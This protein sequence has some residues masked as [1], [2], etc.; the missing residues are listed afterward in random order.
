FGTLATRLNDALGQARRALEPHAARLPDGLLAAFDAL[1]AE[2]AQRRIRIAIYGE[3]KA[4]KS[5][6]LN[7]IAGA[8]LSPVAFEPL[9]SVPVRVTYGASTA[10]HVAE[11]RLD[12]VEELERLMRTD[13]RDAA[14]NGAREVV[15]ETPLD[16]L[17]LGGQVDLVD[18]PGVGNAA[19][20]D[21][22]SAEVLGGLDAVVLVVRYPALFTQFTRH[23]TT[24]L[25]ADIGKLFVVWNLDADCVELAPE[26]RRRHAEVLSA[27]VSGAH[28]LFLVD[29]RA[30]FRAMQA[31]DGAGSIASGLSALIA[32]LRRFISSSG[33]QVAALREAA[34][35]SS[36]ALNDAH[37]CLTERHAT[38]DRMLTDTRTRIQAVQA[39]AD[40]ESVTARKRLAD[41]DAEVTRIG[42]H[43]TAGA[44]QLADNL[45]RHL[46][47]ARRRWMRGGDYR[48]L[49]AAITAALR[50]YAGAA[51][52]A[53]EATI[54]ALQGAA[55]NFGASP[56]LAPRAAHVLAVEQ[57]AAQEQVNRAASG[58]WQWVRRAVWHRWY[59]PG[60]ATLER[61][62]IPADVTSQIAWVN[63]MLQATRDAAR[64]TLA[65]RLG[66]ITQRAQAEAQQI[67]LATNAVANQAEFEELDKHLPLVA[68]QYE[69]V[70]RIGTEAR[71]L[72]P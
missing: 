16:L 48:T 13:A 65:T 3:V 64:A 6:L 27:A 52:A 20:F 57:L 5:T 44:S 31:D 37:R 47:S 63:G 51:E 4:G 39:A 40:A 11:C 25:R 7:A 33:R 24:G 38:L 58:R 61:E 70:A 53:N 10:W 17:Q 71:T 69:A 14:L 18:T 55:N 59:L 62:G 54:R 45:R 23:L 9:T 50:D 36:R 49:E 29:A 60:L 32:A 28:E 68:T 26:E 72:L 8:A 35:R 12:S 30:G 67:R 43:A 2:C 42:Q 41:L 56:T 19:Q 34:K 15:V 66:D 1:L 21:A 46:R 22:V